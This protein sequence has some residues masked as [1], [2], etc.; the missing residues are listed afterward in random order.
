M[1]QYQP[2]I[3]MTK[4]ELLNTAGTCNN[5]RELAT[6]LGNTD[7]KNAKASVKAAYKEAGATAKEVKDS[8]KKSA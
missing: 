7:P 5:V 3:T 4:Q 6:K 1:N 2:I 8:F